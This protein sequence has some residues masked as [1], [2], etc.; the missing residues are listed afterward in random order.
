MPETTAPGPSAATVADNPAE[1]RYELR[2]GGVVA[3][4]AA[5]RDAGGMR[6]FTHTEVDPSH[7]GEGLGSRLA[8]GALDDARE[9]GLRVEPVCRFIAAYIQRHPAYADLVDPAV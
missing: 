1:H 5:Y 7:E 4:F 9:R 8:A 3:G 2:V 6:T